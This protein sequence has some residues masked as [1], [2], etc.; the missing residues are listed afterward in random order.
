MIVLLVS[1]VAGGCVSASRGAVAAPR[2]DVLG[3][4]AQASQYG[5][6]AKQIFDS[7]ALRAKVRA[8]FG[9][10]WSSANPI[11]LPAP[12]PAFFEKS[13]PPMM[14]RIDNADWIGVRG[15]MPTACTTRHGLVLIGPGG[16]R[17]VARVDDGGFTQEYGYGPRMVNVGAQ[18]RALVDAAWRALALGTPHLTRRGA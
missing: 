5:T 14:L 2:V 16:D 17:L 18:D 9:K 11:G 12:V 1:W 10:D 4:S 6:D 3:T 13:S 15:C 8:L 7:P